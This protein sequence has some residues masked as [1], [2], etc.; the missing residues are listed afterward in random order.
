ML[1]E[2]NEK[3]HKVPTTLETSINK[4]ETWYTPTKLV[5]SISAYSDQLRIKRKANDHNQFDP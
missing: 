1:I 5:N 4:Y 3:K 2:S